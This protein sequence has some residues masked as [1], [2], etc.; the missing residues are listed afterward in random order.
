[1]ASMLSSQLGKA[2]LY[3]DAVGK[4]GPGWDQLSWGLSAIEEHEQDRHIDGYEKIV[5]YIRDVIDYLLT[6]EPSYAESLWRQWAA[7]N[8]L[9]FQR[10]S[11]HAVRI[12]PQMANDD[13]LR[14]LLE[15]EWLYKYGLKHEIFMLL[16]DVLPSASKE[17]QEEVV[18][19][20]LRG[21]AA[22]EVQKS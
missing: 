21:P 14:W 1:L 7:S 4:F 22:E 8:I 16:R 13:K 9:I 20:A 6:N 2:V 18:R 17:I 10:L 15:H 3:L 12:S 19:S 11:V 5:H